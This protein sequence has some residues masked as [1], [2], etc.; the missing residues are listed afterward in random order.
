MQYNNYQYQQPPRKFP[1]AGVILGII[2]LLVAVAILF[3]VRESAVPDVETPITTPTVSGVS[4]N[5]IFASV[6]DDNFNYVIQPNATYKKGDPVL[7]HVTTSDFSQGNDFSVDLTE[8]LEVKYQDGTTVFAQRGFSSIKETYSEEQSVLY[9]V[10]TLPTFDWNAGNYSVSIILHDNVAKKQT[11]KTAKFIVEEKQITISQLVF[12]QSIADDYSYVA[13]PS[14]TYSIGADVNVYLE[15]TDFNQNLVDG[16]YGVNFKQG[17]AVF[18]SADEL[19]L[20]REE[21][22]VVDDKNDLFLNK[23]QLKNSFKTT[24]LSPGLYSIVVSALDLNNDQYAGRKASFTI[25]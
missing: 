19:V 4:A 21:Y 6:V 17:F 8:D 23:Y 1:V 5:I 15:I 11:T 2:V 3:Y 10:N 22:L 18:N 12:A 24:G 7:I 9:F 20:I 14:A 13:Q 16:K 25:R